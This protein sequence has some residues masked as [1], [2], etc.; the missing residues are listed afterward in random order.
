M[1]K[2]GITFKISVDDYLKTMKNKQGKAKTTFRDAKSALLGNKNDRRSNGETVSG[3]SIQYFV[4]VLGIMYAGDL[5]KDDLSEYNRL[6]WKNPM[7]QTTRNNKMSRL[8]G[9]LGWAIKQGHIKSLNKEDL[10]VLEQKEYFPRKADQPS[11]DILRR[12]KDDK[13]IFAEGDSSETD[14]FQQLRNFLMFYFCV[15]V[16]GLRPL[17]EIYTLNLK[18]VDEDNLEVTVRRKGSL[19]NA[20]RLQTI[21]F[22]KD[23]AEDIRRY[24]CLRA[25]HIASNKV[26]CN[27]GDGADAFFIRVNPAQSGR[28]KEVSWGLDGPGASLAFRDIC[29]RLGIKM[30]AYMLRHASVTNQMEN[31]RLLGIDCAEIAHR[32]DHNLDTSLN[33]YNDILRYGVEFT[34]RDPEELGTF[35]ERLAHYFLTVF[36]KSPEKLRHY[37]AYKEVMNILG[38]LQ[39]K[40]T[41]KAYRGNGIPEIDSVE[42]KDEV[43]NF[44]K[45]RLG[46]DLDSW[47]S[48]M[49]TMTSRNLFPA[50][51]PA[52]QQ[53]SR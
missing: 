32:N 31:A 39:L 49:G 18:D 30:K 4:D 50:G 19:D 15:F 34:T 46:T 43:R 48:G 6:L 25:K 41:V 2:T 44:L 16:N 12:L 36:L 40:E 51:N 23:F 3:G 38:K 9:Y 27:L 29:S 21:A 14:K 45:Q 5:T 42:T 28:K 53:F 10:K 11:P 33:Y 24:K 37:A 52:S 8:R 26:F 20:E 35:L 1:Q 47:Q 7:K 17:I 22:R 13:T